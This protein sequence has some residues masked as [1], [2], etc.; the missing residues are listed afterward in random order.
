MKN[1]L[2]ALLLISSPCVAQ[3]GWIFTTGVPSGTCTGYTSISIV[4]DGSL[5]TCASGTWTKYGSSDIL[6]YP[7]VGIPNSTGTAWG[8]SFGVSGTGS[9]VALTNNPAL[10]SATFGSTGQS[11]IDTSGDI[12]I[13]YTGS[14]PIPWPFTLGTTGQFHS[15]AAG[16][17]RAT[18]FNG[19]GLATNG[20]TTSYLSG[21]GTYL[22]LPTATTGFPITLGSTSISASSST[23]S[24]SGIQGL[25]LAGPTATADNNFSSG[26]LELTGS[27][28][29]LG[30]TPASWVMQNQIAAGN[31]PTSTLLF[32]PVPG[33]TT[34][35]RIFQVNSDST[36]LEGG[37]SY[38][39]LIGT[40]P[41]LISSGGNGFYASPTLVQIEGVTSGTSIVL[42]PASGGYSYSTTV[43]QAPSFRGSNGGSTVTLT[44]PAGGTGTFSQNLTAENGDLQPCPT[45]T[46]T[47]ALGPASGTSGNG[48]TASVLGTNCGGTVTIKTGSDTTSQAYIFTVT[49]SSSFTHYGFCTFAPASNTLQ[50]PGITPDNVYMSTGQA[51]SF[52]LGLVGTATMQVLAN[53]QWS[54]TCN[55]Y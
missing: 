20:S 22:P 35:S 3:S 30:P 15:D 12:A 51:N 53:H 1:I 55:G 25:G 36:Q 46:P 10:T 7:S 5:W 11:A 45:G 47:V 21:A 26:A 48:A 42:Q 16:N 29:D 44:A 32:A 18:T 13:G 31:T 27:F 19:I 54:Y 40:T 2:F 9:T 39:S 41:S 52:S 49:F 34:G 17:V 23:L 38:L 50:D 28:Y 6:P 37:N 33:G 14:L 24:L 8:T 43:F 4:G